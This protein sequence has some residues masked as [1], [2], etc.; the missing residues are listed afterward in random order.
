MVNQVNP[1]PKTNS[2]VEGS[3]TTDAYPVKPTLSPPPVRLNA[4]V[5]LIAVHGPPTG[6]ATGPAEYVDAGGSG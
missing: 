6:P 2:Q 1:P 3:G 5:T 4:A